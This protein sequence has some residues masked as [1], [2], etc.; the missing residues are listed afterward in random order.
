MY[1]LW[2]SQSQFINSLSQAGRAGRSHGEDNDGRVGA[3][4]WSVHCR[5]LLPATSLLTKL[6]QPYSLQPGEDMWGAAL[7]PVLTSRQ[8]DQKG[9]EDLLC[10]TP[11]QL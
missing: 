10:N 8:K 2:R 1:V 9:T 7:W 3:W 6:I 4:A 11:V 5:G